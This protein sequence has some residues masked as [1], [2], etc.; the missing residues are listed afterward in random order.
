MN[1]IY[2]FSPYCDDYDFTLEQGIDE[3]GDEF[4]HGIDIPCKDDPEWRFWSLY[5][6]DCIGWKLSDDEI[7]NIKKQVTK[8]C[9][10]NGYLYNG[11]YFE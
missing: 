1:K 6:D 10:E 11:K 3:E 2:E 9:L 8:Y 7:E 4:Y 5:E